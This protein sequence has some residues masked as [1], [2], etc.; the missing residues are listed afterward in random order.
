LGGPRGQT[1]R[2]ACLLYVEDNSANF[3]V[4]AAML[5]QQPHLTLLGASSGEYALE[6]VRRH[7]PDAI[8]MD[9]HLPGMDGYAVLEALRADP[10]TRDI[11]V[12]ALS[13]DAM[14]L[15]L[16]RGLQAGFQAYLTKPLRYEALEQALADLIRRG[17]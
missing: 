10:Q 3:R 14:P 9:I 2:K 8:L 17:A 6:L 15:D 13:A 12:F 16:E 7:R 4:V 11:P 1:Q 5:S